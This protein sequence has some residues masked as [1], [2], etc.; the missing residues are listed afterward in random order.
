V[1]K[2]EKLA[3]GKEWIS[4]YA[5]ISVLFMNRR[6]IGF[7]MVFAV[8]ATPFFVRAAQIYL[9]PA[10]GKYPPGVTYAVDVRLDNQNQC[11]NAAEV[12]LAYPANLLQAVGVNDGNS[13]LTLWVKPPTIYSD[14]GLVSFIGGL[15]GGYCGRVSGDPSLSNKLATIYFRFPTSTAPIVSSTIIQ[16]ANLSFLSS[17][18]AVLNDGLGTFAVL[19]TGG[20][21][22]TPHS[23]KGQYVSVDA[24]KDA[25]TNDTTPPEPFTIGV[26]NDPS[27]FSGQWFAAFST[28]DKQTG[29]DHYEVAEVPTSDSNLP[30]D[31]W[32]WIRA[33]SPYLIK[34]QD[35]NKLIAVRA[36]DMAG[37]M[38]VEQYSP[39]PAQKKANNWQ[40]GILPY[41]AIIGIVGF[42]LIQLILR[43]L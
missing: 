25:I 21:T 28:V 32:D 42:A 38:R 37:N 16:S 13:I 24:M 40:I 1:D 31:R 9:D 5:I 10:T 26:Y 2:L 3:D 43:L 33:V 23:P 39:T 35:L 8:L 12:D 14:Y 19:K 7:G 11:V 34:S 20:A 4:H 27:L 6:L 22:Y 29:I 15:P 41:L 18:R 17:T 36:I 30:Q